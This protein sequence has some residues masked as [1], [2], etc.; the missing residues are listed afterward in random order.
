MAHNVETMAYAGDVPWHGLG[1]QVSHNMTAEEMLK[2]AGL[3]WGVDLRHLYIKDAEGQPVHIGGDFRAIV[4]DKDSKLL[5]VVG[6]RFIPT[7]NKDVF[8]FFRE[9]VD[10]GK[11]KMET[12]GSLQGGRYVWA[13]ANLQASFKLRGNDEVKGYLLASSPHQQGKALVFKFTPIRVVCNNTLTL[14]LR[15]A[16]HEFRMNHRNVFDED[17]IIN[18]KEALGIAREQLGEFEKNA[19]LLQKLNLNRDE[20]IRILSPVFQPVEDKEQ[21][22]ELVTD[23]Q[24]LNVRMNAILDANENAPGAQPGNGWGVL[25]AVTYYADH[26]ASKSAD[27]RLFNAWLGKTAG[28]KEKVLDL[29]LARV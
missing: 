24:K 21:L 17:M 6:S 23:P 7:Q 12:A 28:Q 20:V 10:E 2:A 19:R 15:S 13:L 5:D 16:G 1:V 22:E 14:A 8:E 27:K 25:N 4:R 3:D 26:V 29:L 18:A 11:A 9:F